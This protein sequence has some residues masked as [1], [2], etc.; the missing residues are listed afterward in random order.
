MDSITPEDVAQLVKDLRDAGKAECTIATIVRAASRVF[1]HA[2]R[3]CSWNGMNPCSMLEK[4]ERPKPSETQRRRTFTSPEL[5]ATLAAAHEPYRLIFMLAAVSGARESEILGLTWGDVDLGDEDTAALRFGVQLSR[6]GE[7]VSL[8]AQ[9]SRPTVELPRQ[10]TARLLEH[11]AASKHSTSEAFAFATRSGRAISQRNLLR[12]LRRAMSKA[13][14]ERGRLVF[15]VLT[16]RDD[17]GKRVKVPRGSVPNVHRFR[18][19]AASE[20]I[21]AGESVEEVSW[22]LGH[23]NSNVTRVV[24]LQEVKSAERTA[25]RRSKMETRLG[26]LLEASDRSRPQQTRTSEGAEVVSLS[27][28]R[29]A[30]Q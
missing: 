30:A 5:A 26:S 3:R 29:D 8:K 6:K 11:R 16:E 23:R 2:Q 10:L 13:T 7:R 18:H 12:E 9:E 20:A 25:H 15:P 22:Q 4:G 17:A 28:I 19:T 27:A 24:Y 21:A 14:D 1:T